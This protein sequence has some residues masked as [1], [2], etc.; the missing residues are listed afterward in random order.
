MARIRTIKPEF[1][2]HDGLFQAEQET[3]LPLRLAFAGLWTA[4]DR[5]GRFEWRPKQLKLDCLPYD[6]IDFSRVLDALATRGFIVKYE[7]ST[8]AYGY[9]PS[10][11]RHQ[12]INGRESPSKIPKPNE[13]KEMPTRAERVE[14]ACPTRHE[15]AQ[16]EG[17]GE[18]KGNTSPAVVIKTTSAASDPAAGAVPADAGNPDPETPDQTE[19]ASPP[20]APPEPPAPPRLTPPPGS[21]FKPIAAGLTLDALRVTPGVGTDLHEATGALWAVL[22]ANGC[23]G[24]AS[25]PAVIELARQGVTVAELRAAIADAR[26]S[27]TGQL[28][29]AYLAAIVERRRSEGPAKAGKGAKWASD[30]G[31]LDAK[32]RE[33]GIKPLTGETYHDLRSRVRDHLERQAAGT[34]R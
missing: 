4:C 26:K 31:A 22:A 30:D 25:H 15:L 19:A 27:S 13:I 17:E 16:G 21:P 11:R 1:F 18:G 34:V 14:D 12:V 6:E 29:P 10:W 8:G 20:D 3:G 24:T 5:E 23:K 32:A 28:N 33:L 7:L 2:R 9:I